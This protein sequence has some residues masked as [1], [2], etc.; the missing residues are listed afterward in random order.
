MPVQQA[1]DNFVDNAGRDM[2]AEPSVELRGQCPRDTVDIIDAASIARRMNRTE[3]VNQILAEWCVR[4]THYATLIYR[5]SRG[6]P[7][8]SAANGERGE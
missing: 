1:G 4:E 8:P 2:A 7:T 5:A 3:L 6:N